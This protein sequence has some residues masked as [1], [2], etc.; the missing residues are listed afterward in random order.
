LRDTSHRYFI[1]GLI[2]A[3]LAA[4][5]IVV[6]LLT[7]FQSATLETSSTPAP[8]VTLYVV[9]QVSTTGPT[10]TAVSPTVTVEAPAP[11]TV[12]SPRPPVKE[13]NE[14]LVPVANTLAAPT[15]TPEP[16]V[17]SPTP[18]GVTRQVKVPILLFHHVGPLPA[19]PD[20]IRRDLTVSPAQFEE[21]L[22]YLKAAGFH[23]ASLRDLYFYLV[24]GQPLPDKP[25]IL[26]FDD[27]YRDNYEYAFPLLKQYDFKAAFF[28]LTDFIDQGRPEYVTWQQLREMHAGGMEVE[29]H[30]RDHPDLRGRNVDFLVWQILGPDEAIAAHVGERPRF[31]A[32][33]SGTY[34]E[35]VI[36]VLRSDHYWGAL[37]ISQGALQSTD[38]LFELHRIR[39]RGRYVADD[40]ASVI[41]HWLNE[42]E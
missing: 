39:V 37:T 40:L 31:Y 38:R 2:V 33:P 21:H 34:D 11:I 15:P 12:P 3:V 16:L 26:T 6:E 17:K 30:S 27:G 5:M 32:Y 7:H 35:K 41:D 29:A 14:S 19:N 8:T 13:V 42:L 20:A 1:P 18:D 22:Q 4:T 10:A 23:P 24:A 28:V 25:V 9:A 36:E